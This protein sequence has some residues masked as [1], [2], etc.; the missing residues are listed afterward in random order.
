[1]EFTVMLAMEGMEVPHEFTATTD[2][3]PP[4]LPIVAVIVLVVELPVE[5]E[6]NV[7]VY[8]VAPAT[9]GTL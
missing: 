3:T 6:G 4:V 9:E 1:M 5:P 7:H 8:E 2:I